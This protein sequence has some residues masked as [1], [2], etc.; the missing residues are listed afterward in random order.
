MTASNIRAFIKRHELWLLPGVF[1][2]RQLPAR[3]PLTP[4]EGDAPS[5]SPGCENTW[6]KVF[7]TIAP[8]GYG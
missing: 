1:V 5:V 3:Y 8:N 4:V 2:I 6:R 7:A